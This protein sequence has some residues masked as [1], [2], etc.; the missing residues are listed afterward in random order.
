[1]ART[2]RELTES[3]VT[4]IVDDLLAS[5]VRG[6][7]RVRARF[8]VCYVDHG[9][10]ALCREGVDGQIWSRQTMDAGALM[11]SPHKGDALMC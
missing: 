2:T 11:Q 10:N 3:H 4:R 6:V 7:D 9:G 1:M 5:V 8:R